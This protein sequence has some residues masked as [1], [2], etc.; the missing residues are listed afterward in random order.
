MKTGTIVS[1]V[2]LTVAVGS[3]GYIVMK[4]RKSEDD[5]SVPTRDF[6]VYLDTAEG[7]SVKLETL[8]ET[9]TITS[10]K[11]IKV[12]YSETIK[13]TA[14][15]KAG[16]NFIGWTFAPGGAWVTSS[17]YSVVITNDGGVSASFS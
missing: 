11:T 16:H 14:L 4:A 15:P 7:G 5:P 12:P 17:V 6:E 1:L 2:G 9:Y 8:T 3:I 13:L 10:T